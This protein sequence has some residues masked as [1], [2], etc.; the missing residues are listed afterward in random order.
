MSPLVLVFVEKA[1]MMAKE[2][3]QYLVVMKIIWVSITHFSVSLFNLPVTPVL[4]KQRWLI[5]AILYS[6][7]FTASLHRHH[8]GHGCHCVE[9]TES[10]HLTWLGLY[11][12][13]NHIRQ[14]GYRV[15]PSRGDTVYVAYLF[16]SL[17]ARFWG[18]TWGPPGAE[19]TQV[20][21]MLAPWTLISGLLMTHSHVH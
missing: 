8:D 16:L 9:G 5:I 7:H 1:R 2:F 11:D 18:P 10:D 20:G 15:L 14:H 6:I 13:R 12:Y 19:R 3:S 4:L 17:I 21:H